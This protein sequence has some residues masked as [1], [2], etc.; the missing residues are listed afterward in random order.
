MTYVQIKKKRLLVTGMALILLAV[1][2]LFCIEPVFQYLFISNGES[3]MQLIEKPEVQNAIKANITAYFG[4]SKSNYTLQD[5]FEWQNQYLKYVD[6]FPHGRPSN[7]P[8]DILKAGVG[9]CGE[10]SNLFVAACLS[11]G[12]EAR[13]A[14]VIKTDYTD[15][16]HALCMVKINETWTQIDSSANAPNTLVINDTSVYQNWYWG[17][18][19]GKDYSVFDFDA[20]NAYNVTNYFV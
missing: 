4:G 9:R 2:L 8:R 13:I 6:S 7:D 1:A 10:F 15:G 12:Y 16:P 19:V 18:R 14:S 11:V 5:L 20:N 17:P 3:I